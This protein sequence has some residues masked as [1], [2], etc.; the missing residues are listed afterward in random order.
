MLT[1]LKKLKVRNIPLLI[2]SCVASV[3]IW[4][5][6]MSTINPE[7]TI[8]FQD[9]DVKIQGTTMLYER[10]GYTIL[11]DTNFSFDIELSGPRNLILKL[12]RSDIDIVCDVSNVTGSGEKRIQCSI[13]TPYNDISVDNQKDLVVTLEVDKIIEE[14]KSLRYELT[15]ELSS[16]Y[17]VGD[18][19]LSSG[20]IIVSGPATELSKISYGLISADIT[21]LEDTTSMSLPVALIGDSGE[22]VELR[23]TQQITKTADISIPVYLIREVPLTIRF[24][25]G[26]GLTSDEVDYKITPQK[27]TLVGERAVL[28]EIEYISL[29]SVDLDGIGDGIITEK[30]FLPPS[31]TR[32][33]TDRSSATVEVNVKDIETRTFRINK[34]MLIGSIEGFDSKVTTDYVNVRLRGNAK[35]L[36]AIT[37]DDFTVS[38]S[39]EN[40]L[41]QAGNHFVNAAVSFLPTVNAEI[42]ESNYT[43]TVN[44]RKT[45]T[46]E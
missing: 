37:A 29:G 43:V 27:V 7:M 42:I 34:I 46:T 19:S 4:F 45:G 21:G 28:S 9:I 18:P 8:R 14:E 26:G 30:E 32:C 33:L 10:L 38:V 41:P 16:E 11:S 31:G 3:V 44:L 20:K 23:Y 5:V 40:V 35:V 24:N 22:P 17:M 1:L 2:I 36:D 15:G 13:T 12:K 25:S 39:L 6:V